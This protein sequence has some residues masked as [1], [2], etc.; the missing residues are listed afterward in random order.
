MQMLEPVLQRHFHRFAGC[1]NRL[2][3]EVYFDADLLANQI[4]GHSPTALR[5]T[6]RSPASW[7]DLEWPESHAFALAGSVKQAEPRIERYAAGSET[8]FASQHP[9]HLGVAEDRDGN[10]LADAAAARVGDEL[11]APGHGRVA[12]AS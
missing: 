6:Q 8:G 7:V 10:R 9:F 5:Q 3:V 11:P 2:Q 12:A 1:L 4:F